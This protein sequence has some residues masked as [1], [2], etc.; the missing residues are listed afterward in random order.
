MACPCV[1]TT[2]HGAIVST[3]LSG[4]HDQRLPWPKPGKI[5]QNTGLLKGERGSGFTVDQLAYQ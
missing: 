4:G 3:P 2:P 5:G 1:G